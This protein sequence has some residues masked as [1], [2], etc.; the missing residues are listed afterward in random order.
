M[1]TQSNISPFTPELK[2]EFERRGLIKLS[3]GVDPDAATAMAARLWDEL[4]RRFGVKPGEPETWSIVRPTGLG[5]LSKRRAFAAMASP[6]VVAMIDALLGAGRWTPPKHWGVPLVTFP[7]RAEPWEVPDQS[8]HL[9]WPV[10]PT[11][12]A[13]ARAFVLLSALQPRCGGTLVVTGSHLLLRRIATAEERTLRS[14]EARKRLRAKHSW[15]DDLCS[16]QPTQERAEKFMAAGATIDG[17]DVR[18]VEMTGEPGDVYFMH[19]SLLH[20]PSQNVGAAPRMMV[21]QLVAG[22]SVGWTQ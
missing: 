12:V 19:P 20:A 7:D 11:D 3:R 14:A 22:D 16:K 6:T 9:D 10:A 8:W 2:N 4:E 21:T 13:I 1:K 5:A 18:A 15:F 17:V